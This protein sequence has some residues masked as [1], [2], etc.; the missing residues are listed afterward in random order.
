MSQR[1][2]EGTLDQ[3]AEVRRFVRLTAGGHEAMRLAELVTS[4]LAA[5][6]V[7]HSASGEPGG[8]FTVETRFAPNEVTVAVTDMGAEREPAARTADIEAVSGRGLWMVE[9]LSLKWGCEPAET[10]RRVWAVLP[11]FTDDQHP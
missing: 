11:V 5:N 4:E 3:L 1:R 8:W 7:L 9:T 2:F 10:G 6:A